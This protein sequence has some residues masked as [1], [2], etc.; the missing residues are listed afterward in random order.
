METITLKGDVTP[1]PA[2]KADVSLIAKNITYDDIKIDSADLEVSGDEKL[3][4]LTLD[5]VSDIV[6]SSLEIEGTFK[7]KPEMIWDG[8]LRRL[9][10]STPQGPWALQSRRQS[11]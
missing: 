1:L 7:Q 8:A 11:K 4:Q 10:L 5:V 2:P 6:S 3:H 9:T